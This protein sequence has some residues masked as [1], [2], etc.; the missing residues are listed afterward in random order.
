MIQFQCDYCEGTHPAILK[1]LTETN[2]VQ[3]PG[4]GEDP[5]CRQA[6]ETIRA[7]C[8]APDADVHFMV[9]G[10]PCNLT[11]IA[12]A[13]RPYQGVISADTGHI[14]VHESGAIE[15]T[16]HKVL[17]LSSPDGKLTAEQVAQFCRTY[18]ADETHT[19]MVQPKMVYISNPTEIGTIYSRAELTA[20]SGVCRENGLYLY[21]D[22]ARL[23]Y[24]LTARGCDLDLP[25]I[26]ALCDA[27][28]IGGTKQ[29]A[30]L[31]EALVLTSDALKAD[32]RYMIK[33]QGGLLAKGWL[34]GRQ[35][36]A[37]LKDGL[38]GLYFS[39]ARHANQMAEKIAGACRQKGF[40]FLIDSPTNQQ[41]P[42]LPDDACQKLA[43]KYSFAYWSRVDES[44]S[45]V[46]FCTSWATGEQSVDA[47]CADIAAL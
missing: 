20:L 12:A 45:A 46:R 24:G 25:A 34:I 6:A 9:G 19:H 26:A 11:V 38:D 2:L 31:G 35:F 1:L 42:I 32:F 8:A 30:L 44:H 3:Q 16:G 36:E 33:R 13:L 17:A 43:Q 14:N 5:V 28:Y 10:T 37:L 29:G 47:L 18:W 41:F 23:G 21:M 15:A 39:L 22:G 4:Y 27:F 40:S 7:L